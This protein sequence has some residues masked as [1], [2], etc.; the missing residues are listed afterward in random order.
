MVCRDFCAF[1]RAHRE[2]CCVASPP[3]DFVHAHSLL[4]LPSALDTPREK[5]PVVACRVFSFFLLV[6]A[7]RVVVEL[8]NRLATF[9][10]CAINWQ[11]T[12]IDRRMKKRR[13]PGHTQKGQ[14]RHKRHKKDMS[15]RPL[16][17]FLQR[18]ASMPF[19]LSNGAV[20]DFLFSIHFINQDR[21]WTRRT[22]RRPLGDR[23]LNG[24]SRDSPWQLYGGL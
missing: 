7:R 2:I 24:A 18:G 14:K 12:T 17:H 13:L 10:Y 3:A 23:S 19:F 16:P 9:F 11:S 6:Q 15:R 1:G 8:R 21:P 5:G 4:S 22:R 20:V